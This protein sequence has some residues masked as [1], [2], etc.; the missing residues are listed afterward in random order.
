MIE[1]EEKRARETH[2]RVPLVPIKSSFIHLAAQR[3]I[4]LICQAQDS[5]LGRL[6]EPCCVVDSMAHS[7]S[8]FH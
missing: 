4:A 5:G 8:C 2:S 7:T 3:C 6:S 1:E